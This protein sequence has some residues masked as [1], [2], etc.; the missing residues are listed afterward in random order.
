MNIG[1]ANLS[2]T[3]FFSSDESTSLIAQL[4]VNRVIIILLAG[5]SIPTSGFLMQEYFQ[6]PLAGPEVLGITSVASLAVATYIF[7]TKDFTLPEFLQ[8]GLISLMAFGGSLL[9]MLLLLAYSKAFTDKTY[10]IIFGFLISALASAIVSIMQVYAQSESLKSYILW[11]FGANNQVN[12]SQILIVSILVLLGM[13]L[14]FR[15]IKPLMGNALG[16]SYAKSF[17]VNLERLKY[18]VIVCS[19]LLS[20][21]IT[22][23]LGPIL[24]IGIVVPHFCRMLWNPAQ[25]WQQWI[26]NMLFGACLL[27]LF[28]LFPSWF[29]GRLILFPLCLVYLLF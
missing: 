5:I 19:S 12:I 11:S 24:F 29:T 15:A 10:L 4:R 8:S 25:L 7:L 14:C 21:S 3:D 9:L 16:E 6:N 17:G 13:F 28:L 1:F 27:E 26:L 22:A 2:F 18:L 23:F 20:A